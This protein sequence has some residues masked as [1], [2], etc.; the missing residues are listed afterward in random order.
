M[1]GPCEHLVGLPDE[2]M[3]TPAGCESCLEIGGTWVHL[4]RCLV[5][6]RVGCCDDSPNRHAR[7]HADAHG[8]PVIRSAE[9]G[10]SWAWCY[11]H[12]V[13]ARLPT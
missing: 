9:P 4:R 8:H 1:S 5:C 6:G 10:E 13:A 12:E 11:E 2:A 7:A 3:E